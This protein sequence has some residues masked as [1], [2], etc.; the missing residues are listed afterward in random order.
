MSLKTVF[1]TLVAVIKTVFFIPPSP[2]KSE[3]SVYGIMHASVT[4]PV[5]FS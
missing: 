2:K 3:V 1:D 4:T 5:K